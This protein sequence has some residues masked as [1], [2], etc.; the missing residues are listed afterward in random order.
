MIFFWCAVLWYFLLVNVNNMSVVTFSI[1]LD[2][3]IMQINSNWYKYWTVRKT[4]C[5]IYENTSVNKINSNTQIW[6]ICNIAAFFFSF[7]FSSLFLFSLS[8]IFW[9]LFSHICVAA[10]GYDRCMFCCYFGIFSLTNVA[11]EWFWLNK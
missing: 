10:V 1:V 6:K 4:E 8:P 9:F 7:L 2:N 3:N 11:M 5:K